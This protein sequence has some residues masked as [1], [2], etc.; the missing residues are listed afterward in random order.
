MPQ[1]SPGFFYWRRLRTTKEVIRIRINISPIINNR[2]HTY[3]DTRYTH[4]PAARGEVVP[5]YAVWIVLLHLEMSGMNTRI[6]IDS[7]RLLERIMLE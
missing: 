4:T 6:V 5:C 1:V 7:E 2:T 3:W